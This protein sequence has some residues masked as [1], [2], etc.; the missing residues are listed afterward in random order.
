MLTLALTALLATGAPPADPLAPLQFLSGS[1]FLGTFADG[2]TKDL[3][4]YEPMIGGKFLRSRHRVIDGRGPYSGET[5]YGYDATAGKLEFTYFNSFGNTMRGTLESTAD[6][7]R[8]PDE[9]AGD[10]VLRSSWTKTADGYVATTEKQD[11]EAWKPF[12]KIVF[13]RQGP[14]SAW[15]ER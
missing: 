2:K 12:M 1:C 3:V 13:V 8:F 4:C 9:K 15:T 5:I 14:A 7:M 6:G 10:I 11:G